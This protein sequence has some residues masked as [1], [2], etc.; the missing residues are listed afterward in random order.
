[1]RY[2]AQQLWKTHSD[3]AVQKHS[4]RQMARRSAQPQ[5]RREKPANRTSCASARPRAHASQRLLV[6]C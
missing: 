4:Q 2:P 6:S 3:Q 1:M 5:L